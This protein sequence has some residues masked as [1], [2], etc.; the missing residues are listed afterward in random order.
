M[1]K[2]KRLLGRAPRKVGKLPTFPG[3]VPRRVTG[4]FCNGEMGAPGLTKPSE[5]LEDREQVPFF[6]DKW[7][8]NPRDLGIETGKSWE[9]VEKRCGKDVCQAKYGYNYITMSTI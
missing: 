9:N 4:F 6:R 1:A 7:G 2:C 8:K 3:R 5:T